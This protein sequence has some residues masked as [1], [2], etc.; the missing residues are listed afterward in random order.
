MLA[1]S[2]S[3]GP[4]SNRTAGSASIAA[5]RFHGWSS[6][7]WMKVELN[8]PQRRADR[9]ILVDQAAACPSRSGDPGFRV[10]Q[11]AA[12]PSRLGGRLSESIR[13]PLVHARTHARV[14]ACVRAFVQLGLGRP[15]LARAPPTRAPARPNG[16]GV[17]LSA[18][19]PPV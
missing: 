2:S 15:A 16:M 18:P 14:R 11:A 3:A 7:F 10:D 19:P 1:R 5:G 17:R 13:R 8:C 12:C 9:W 6:A 4:K